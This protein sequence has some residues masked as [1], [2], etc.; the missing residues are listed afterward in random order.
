MGMAGGQCRGYDHDTPLPGII[1]CTL[2]PHRHRRSGSALDLK[3][4]RTR[5]S[6]AE[7]AAVKA[8]VKRAEETVDLI[9]IARAITRLDALEAEIDA[10]VEKTEPAN[11]DSAFEQVAL[12]VTLAISR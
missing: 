5:H 4:E 7:R 10:T 1:A 9:G 11:R 2:Q 12:K 6:A 3:L 8:E